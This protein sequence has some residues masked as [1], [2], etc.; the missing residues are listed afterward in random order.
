MNILFFSILIIFFIYILRA[1]FI[2]IINICRFYLNCEFSKTVRS[3]FIEKI[4]HLEDFVEMF[5]KITV[6]TKTY[7]IVFI[8]H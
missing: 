8:C 3:K 7:L 6:H 2:D 1:T 4:T 5:G